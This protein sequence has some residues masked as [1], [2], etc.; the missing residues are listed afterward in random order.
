MDHAPLVEVDQ[1][2]LAWLQAPLTHDLALRNRQYARLRGHDHEVIFGNAIPRGTQAIAVER[3]T[4]L[5]SIGKDQGG[6]AIPGLHHRGM[7]F[8]E[9]PAARVHGGVLL[10]GLGDHHHHRMGQGIARGHQQLKTVIKGG[11]VGLPGKANRI[12][13]LEIR[14]QHR[15]GHDPLS[16]SHPVVV[17]LHGIDF[18]VVG[19]HTIR[20]RE[21]P[22][23]EGVGGEPLVHECEG[24]DTPGVGQVFVVDAYLVCQQ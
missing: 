13:L 21:R 5:A 12:E 18:P 14:T 16:G 24:R 2:H 17:A 9:G 3:G 7:V 19:H 4:D 20:V 15:G 6:R 23:R 10:P 22:L 11:R 1:E 8:V